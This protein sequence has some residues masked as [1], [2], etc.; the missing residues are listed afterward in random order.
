[1]RLPR[2][3]MFELEDLVWF[4][5]TIR[6][7][8]TD[9]MHFLE[10][11]FALH[12]P[13]VPLLRNVLEKCK[14]AHVVDLCSGGGG[15]VQ[16]V[17]EALVAQG[18]SVPFTLT[19]KYPNLSA[20]RG[21][22]AL[23]P[24]GILYTADSVDATNVPRNLVGLRTM[25]NAFHHFPPAAA[26]SVLKCAVEARQPIAVFEFPERAPATILPL[27][28]T[29]L[30]VAM[31]TPF[32]RPFRWRRL[33]WTYVLPLVPLTS[34]WDGLV[35]QCRAYTVEELLELTQGM[36]DYEWTSARVPIGVTPGHLTY[37]MGIPKAPRT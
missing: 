11:R 20:F 31:A 4:P 17:Y 35:S 7:L 26:R 1:M 15:P 8:A 9:Y 18:I 27:L 32:I 3:Q 23:H 2:L 33:L 5:Q 12:K 24:V 34:W 16:G 10:A 28:F 19:D 25:F 22:S 36:G 37:L 29:P 21:L 6:D 30:F 13:V 14:A